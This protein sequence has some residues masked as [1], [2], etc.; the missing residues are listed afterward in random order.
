M[1]EREAGAGL[2]LLWTDMEALAALRALADL[3]PATQSLR[4]RKAGAGTR[5]GN[6]P[7]WN[8]NAR[9]ALL[10]NKP[11]PA[12]VRAGI[13]NGFLPPI[14]RSLTRAWPATAVSWRS[15]KRLWRGRS[16]KARLGEELD[17]CHA[18]G[19]TRPAGPCNRLPCRNDFAGKTVAD[20]VMAGLAQARAALAELPRRSRERMPWRGPKQIAF[21]PISIPPGQRAGLDSV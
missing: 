14:L 19:K 1:A 11:W 9:L 6:C 12:L 13:V 2:R 18:P 16:R 3:H 7:P 20:G 8:K 10:Q 5:P 21:A 15:G 4:E 17:E